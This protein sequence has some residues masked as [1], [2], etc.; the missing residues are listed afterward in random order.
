MFKS[1][2]KIGWRNLVH[3]PGG[4]LINVGG[5]AIGIACAVILYLF[6]NSEFGYDTYYPNADG[7]YRL[8]THID[9]NGCILA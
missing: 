4:S 8:Y 6:A 9:L 3:N 2:F 7:I 1:Y 5:L